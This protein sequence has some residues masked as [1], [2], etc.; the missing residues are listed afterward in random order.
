MV[1][2]CSDI[3]SENPQSSKTIFM[4]IRIMTQI[5]PPSCIWVSDHIGQRNHK[6]VIF[7]S[8]GKAKT[9]P[10]ISLP[11]WS[12]LLQACIQP[13]LWRAENQ[14]QGVEDLLMLGKKEQGSLKSCFIIDNFG[15]GWERSIC[16]LRSIEL[17]KHHWE[18]Q[19]RPGLFILWIN[20]FPFSWIYYSD[21][22][23]SLWKI[24]FLFF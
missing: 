18:N 19:I 10:E 7:I 12:L 23:N 21:S 16:F 3:Y 9:I 11:Q 6:P 17:R 8:W 2:A 13:Y 15:S 24:W 1:Y 4:S 22:L 20:L 5:I 14:K